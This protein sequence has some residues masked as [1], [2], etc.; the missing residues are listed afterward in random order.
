MTDPFPGCAGMRGRA[1]TDKQAAALLELRL[2]I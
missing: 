2:D 1:S